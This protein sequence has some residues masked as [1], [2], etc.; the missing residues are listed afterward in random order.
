METE[1]GLYAARW[2]GMNNVGT[3]QAMFAT[4]KA[5]N[6]AEFEAAL[7]LNAMP[8][9]NF[10][11]ADKD[12]NIAHYYNAMFPD[13]IEGWQ[14]D[15]VLPGD[16]SEL[17]WQDYRNFSM[18]P[19]TI[20]PASGLVYNANNPPF[21]ATDGD[22][23]LQAQPQAKDYPASMGIETFVT[24]RAYQIEGLF[25]DV[26]KI[27][28]EQLRA[29]K[30]DVSYH[31]QSNQ[32]QQ[33]LRWIE[34]NPADEFNDLEQQAFEHLKTWDFS[35]HKANL[36]AAL[37]VM[38]LDPVQKA[39]GPE[40]ALNEITQAFKQAVSQLI[41]FHGKVAVPYGD[42][43][44]LIHG[45][46]NLAI[47]GGPDTL[48]AVYGEALNDDGQAVNKAGDGFLMFV[49]WDKHGLVKSNAIHQFGSATLDKNSP[50][51]NDQM[52]LFVNHQERKVLFKREDLEK[53]LERRYSP[54]KNTQQ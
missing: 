16:R 5:S 36:Q 33:L 20:N 34:S 7:Q 27:S 21:M 28:Y 24:N 39:R 51:Y 8:S 52:E 26:P 29:V 1:Q 17:I 48:R 35:T 3:L 11:Y 38:T 45:D 53:N 30:Y 2:A 25:Q 40:I 12:G 47:S 23:P 13:R 42:V 49:A 22:D 32:I 41:Q 19:K 44:R 54:G 4:N 31:K 15:K 9:I 18:M 46:K 6:Q 14:W 50:H 10:V 37:A 43:V